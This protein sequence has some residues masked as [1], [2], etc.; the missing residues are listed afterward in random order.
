[1]VTGNN[2]CACDVI[3]M[4]VI[5]MLVIVMLFFVCLFVRL[6]VCFIIVVIKFK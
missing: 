2:S 1:M 3:V 5:V 6:F 4:L